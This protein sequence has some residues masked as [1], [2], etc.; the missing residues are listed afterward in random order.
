MKLNKKAVAGLGLGVAALVGGTFA[1]YNQT[2]SLDNPL[3][4]G[5][6]N[7][8][9]TEEFNPP[10]EDLMPGQKWEKVV[11]AE[12]TGDYP[13][14]VRVKMEEK[15]VLKDNTEVTL[16]SSEEE[17]TA[18]TYD[19]TT[20]IFDA[21][22]LDDTDGKTE[23]EDKTQKDGTVVY[24]AINTENGWIDG[25]DG[26][27]YWN[28]VLEK[29]DPEN[30]DSKSSADPLMDYLVLANDIDLGKYTTTE[31][32]AIAAKGTKASEIAE[33][34]WTVV[35]ATED[36]LDIAEAQKDSIG[37]GETLIRKSVSALDEEAAGY[38]DGKYTLTITADF[39][40]A[41][42]DAVTA[43]WCENDETKCNKLITETLNKVKVD[44]AH[45]TN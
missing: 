25:K 12:N 6:Y 13:V 38:A 17:F 9:V 27:W 39:V 28:G 29:R 5:N 40:Q 20:G 43:S 35:G 30:P 34:K 11:G 33:D 26:Y 41:T 7:T 23:S 16:D 18:G 44:G 22:Q 3:S 15:W 21:S 2:V 24:K 37:E 14:L 42:T 10:T 19:K 31:Y 36:I 45:I 32:W 8:Q 1:Y 4:T